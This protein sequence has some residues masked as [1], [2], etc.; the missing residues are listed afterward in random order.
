M[1]TDNLS[2]LKASTDQRVKVAIVD[3]DGVLRGKIMRRNK[4]IDAIEDGSG[5]CDVVFGW[6]VA[7]VSYTSEEKDLTGWHT[8][9]PDAHYYPDINTLRNIPWEEDIPFMLGDFSQIDHP[10]CSR[11]LLK[12]IIQKAE[13]L[14][15]ETRFAQE[16]EWFNFDESP[17]TLAE[18]GGINPKPLTPGMFGY[19]VL[20]ASQQSPY[21]NDLF[22]LM[23]AYGIPLEGIHTE[24]GP[25]VYEAAMHYSDILEAADRAVLFKAGVKE[26][27]ARHGVMA[28]F[29][30]KWNHELPGCSGHIHQS[31]WK[32]GKNT[33]HDHNSEN[34][35]SPIAESFMAGQL[36]ALPQLLPMYAPTINSYKRLVEGAWAPTTLTWGMDN[37]T[38]ALRII[39]PSE[40]ATRV[41]LRVPGSDVNPYL[42]MAAAL[43][44]G[45]YGIEQQL[46]LTIPPTKGNGYQN[47]AHG[48]LPPDLKT[49]TSAMKSSKLARELF[50]DAFVDHFC[51]TRE[52]E[53]Q[54]F[55]ASVTDWELKRYFEII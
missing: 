45:L 21:F 54:Q 36:L 7:D 8:G 43:A 18:K 20:R 44:S 41:E 55:A 52:W 30:A 48:T 29:M 37:R 25:G 46:N 15:F 10:A 3:I 32:D 16:F 1:K 2:K 26:I 24:T 33:F 9:F 27:A 35:L 47:T 23:D 39:N 13:E 11:S 22:T 4:A 12:K 28:S 40:K 17:E 51:K 5:F 19:S 42:A 34:G 49:A 38:T 6:D 14:G 50:G 53:W 31:L